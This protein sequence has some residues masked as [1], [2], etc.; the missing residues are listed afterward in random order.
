MA[1]ALASH[2]DGMH[3]HE[4]ARARRRRSL[5]LRIAELL[6]NEHEAFVRMPLSPQLER[7]AQELKADLQAKTG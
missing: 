6:N 2:H 5:R 3:E 4:T 7:L 1:S